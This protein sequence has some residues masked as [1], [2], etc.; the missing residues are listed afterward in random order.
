MSDGGDGV[1]GEVRVEQIVGAGV[2]AL[3]LVLRRAA[4]DGDRQGR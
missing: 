1:D 3:G 4:G 2:A